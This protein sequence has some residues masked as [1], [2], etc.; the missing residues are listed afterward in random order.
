M[1]QANRKPST[2]EPVR[3]MTSVP[4][5]KAVGLR[6]LIQ[7]STD[8]RRTAPAKPPS[9]TR[10][11]CIVG[12]SSEGTPMMLNPPST[13]VISPVIAPARS[14][15]RNAAV[16]PTSSLVTCARIGAIWSNGP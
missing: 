4:N 2:N 8:Q 10:S 1:T 9:P 12:Q 16:L 15:A 13:K 14:E 5:G 11:S 3:L 7:P 6:S